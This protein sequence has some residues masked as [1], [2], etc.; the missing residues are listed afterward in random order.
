MM[1]ALAKIM[2][3][4]GRVRLRLYQPNLAEAEIS[5]HWREQPRLTPGWRFLKPASPS[6]EGR[7]NDS[8]MHGTSALSGIRTGISSRV[9]VSFLSAA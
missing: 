8:Q 9:V 5:F 2:I 1:K 3:R 6:P 7:P 4:A